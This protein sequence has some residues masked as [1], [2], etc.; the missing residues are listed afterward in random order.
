MNLIGQCV[1]NFIF[2]KKV[3]GNVRRTAEIAFGEHDSD[4]FINLKNYDMNPERISYGWTSNNSI[5]GKIGMD[6]EKVSKSI[7]LNGE[8]GIA[9][10]DNMQKYSRMVKKNI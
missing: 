1:G 3:S 7:Q 2:N 4:E 5:F 6:Y 10:L 8:P 9:Y